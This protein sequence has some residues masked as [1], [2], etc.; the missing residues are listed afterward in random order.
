MVA[1]SEG[2]AKVWD[3]D[4]LNVYLENPKG[5]VPGTKMIFPGA[6]AEEDRANVIAYLRTLAAEPAPLQ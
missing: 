4:T 6:K 2:G 1:F 3:Y 5:V